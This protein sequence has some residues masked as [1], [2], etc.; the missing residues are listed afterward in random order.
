[1]SD[2]V[3]LLESVVNNTIN[4][5][6]QVALVVEQQDSAALQTAIDGVTNAVNEGKAA[7]NVAAVLINNTAQG[8]NNAASAVLVSATQELSALENIAEA[9]IQNFTN[10]LEQYGNGTYDCV[11]NNRPAI[12]SVIGTAGKFKG[13]FFFFLQL[14]RAS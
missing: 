14:H 3:S 5:V 4:A 13:V 11:Y 9:S 12:I 2:L 10:V 8:I 1:M 7:V 6:A